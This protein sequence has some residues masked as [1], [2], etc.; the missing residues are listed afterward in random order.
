MDFL[1][2]VIPSTN[3]SGISVIKSGVTKIKDTYGNLINAYYRIWSDGYIEQYGS[4]GKTVQNGYERATIYFPFPFKSTEYFYSSSASTWNTWN[5]CLGID[6]EK[7]YRNGVVIFVPGPASLEQCF[8]NTWKVCGYIDMT[9][10]DIDDPYSAE[11]DQSPQLS[12][13][14]SIVYAKYT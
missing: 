11:T 2:K 10:V 4:P 12:N 8:A 13:D 5:A 7:K 3:T 9:K 6:S 1:K 14:D